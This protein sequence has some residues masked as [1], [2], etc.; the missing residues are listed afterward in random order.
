MRG[1]RIP[2]PPATRRLIL[3]RSGGY[4]ANPSCRRDLFPPVGTEGE[5]ATV[6]KLAHIIGQSRLGPRGQDA[7]PLAARNDA[8]NII[9]LCPYCHDLVDDVNAADQFTPEVL[10]QWKREHEDRVRHG[11]AV[12]TYEDRSALNDEIRAL[13]RRNHAVWQR[14]SPESEA[15][16]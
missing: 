15:G 3:S 13:L 5:V 4:C 8:S 9:L 1:L 11:A 12:P 16:Q 14:Y 6:G 10:R 2:I 7:M